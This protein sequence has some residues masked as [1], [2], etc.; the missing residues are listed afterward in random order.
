MGHVFV[1]SIRTGQ[2]GGGQIHL[3]QSAAADRTVITQ[4]EREAR[5]TAR[6]N[7]QNIGPSSIGAYNGVRSGSWSARWPVLDVAGRRTHLAVARDRDLRQ[8][9][10]GVSH[11][12]KLDRARDLKTSNVLVCAT[13]AKILDFG[14]SRF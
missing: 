2:D 8:V 1:P 6:L 11:A 4:L 10:R 3:A 9:A 13:P 12:H 5:V 7:H 14:I